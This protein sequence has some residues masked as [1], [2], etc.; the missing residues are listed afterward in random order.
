MPPSAPVTDVTGF[1]ACDYS[2]N[3]TIIAFRGSESRL[4]WKM[5]VEVLLVDI[6]LCKGCRAA[7]GFWKSWIESRDPVLAAIN[8]SQ[9]FF[10]GNRIVVTGHSLGG[11]IATLAAGALRKAGF[12]VDLVQYSSLNLT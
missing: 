6:D 12:K 10:P 5:N 2:H 9:K 8:V 7:T 1:V 3:T 4:N 11:A